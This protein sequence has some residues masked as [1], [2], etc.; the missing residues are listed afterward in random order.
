MSF[1]VLADVGGPIL[2]AGFGIVAYLALSLLE[3]IVLR[4]LKWG[5]FWRSLL[6]SLLMNLPSTL[7]GI[8]LVWLAGF[9]RLN[10]L[11]I[12]LIPAAWALSVAIEGGVLVLMKRDGGRQNWMAALAANTAS[13]LLLLAQ[14]V[15][16]S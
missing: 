7:V 11:G 10:R 4:L 6:A 16:V 8:W 15:A 14:R 1:G 5:T 3:S 13:Y 12:W 2:F 9:S